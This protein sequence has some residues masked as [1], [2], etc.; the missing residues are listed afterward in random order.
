VAKKKQN[1]QHTEAVRRKRQ[2]EEDAAKI[3]LRLDDQRAVVGFVFSHLDLSHIA[4]M[5]L[6][7]INDVCKRYAGLDICVFRQHIRPECVVPLCPVFDIDELL[8]WHSFPLVSTSIGTSISAL[9]SNASRVYHYA[10]DPEFI[11]RPD[12]EYHD[13]MM[14]FCDPRIRVIVRHPSHKQLIEE[15][16]S[17]S[18]CDT[19]VPDFDVELL[20]KIALTEMKNE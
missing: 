19:I 18:V 9:S 7:S 3:G 17:I 14:A 1:K 12:K 4:F 15:E 5:G 16:F 8:R 20:S 11:G 13:T 6:N 2:A 10:F